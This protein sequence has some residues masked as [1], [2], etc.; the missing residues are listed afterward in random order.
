MQLSCWRWLQSTGAQGCSKP[1]P[2]GP[3]T[4]SGGT[5]PLQRQEGRQAC[6]HSMHLLAGW[7]SR[8]SATAQ[9]APGWSG[10][11]PAE[12]STLMRGLWARSPGFQGRSAALW[13]VLWRRCSLRSAGSLCSCPPCSARPLPR[14]LPWAWGPR[15]RCGSASPVPSCWA[16]W[17]PSSSML[18]H[19]MNTDCGT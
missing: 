7:Y 16:W 5:T 4:R 17:R 14:P 13:E 18:V 10:T 1:S 8:P 3:S 11:S 15:C 12:K 19:H 9:E 2:A 6:M